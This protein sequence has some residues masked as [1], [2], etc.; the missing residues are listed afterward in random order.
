ME[1]GVAVWLRDNHGDKAWIATSILSKVRSALFLPSYFVTIA[2]QE[3]KDGK[4]VVTVRNEQSG[5]DH[6]FK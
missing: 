6:S 2:I 5:E 4:I 1:V 3:R